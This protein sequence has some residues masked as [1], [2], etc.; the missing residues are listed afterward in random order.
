MIGIY[1]ITN[2]I[3]GKSYIGYSKN[4]ERRFWEHR[5]VSHEFN[6][7]MRADLVKYGKD[8][9]S[10]EVLEEC[11]PEKLAERE[12]FYI[13]KL[14]PEY[15]IL[16]GGPRGMTTAPP[17][18]RERLANKARQQWER[19]TQEEKDHIIKNNLKPPPLGHYVS[20][21]TR[22]KLREKNLGKKQSEETKQ[23]RSDT[24]RKRREAG[25]HRSGASHYKR[26][27]CIDTGEEFLSVKHAAEH[28]G[29]HP[30]RISS[31]LKGRQITTAGHFFE[32]VKV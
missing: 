9:F 28:F 25:I 30:S 10:Y 4:I 12:I 32:Y 7:A 29:I 31:V 20:P 27:R 13:S 2:K 22:Q 8:N 6:K 1:K 14:K 11:E 18:L 23:K 17:E 19:K 5:C 21:E 26:V 15:N 3:N 16:G 24:M